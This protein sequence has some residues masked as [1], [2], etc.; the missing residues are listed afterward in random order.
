M[1]LRG[2]VPFCGPCN[3]CQGPGPTWS[4]LCGHRQVFASLDP[5][6]FVC[7]KRML[8]NGAGSRQVSRSTCLKL[9]LFDLGHNGTFRHRCSFK[10]LQPWL[11]MHTQM[12]VVI[13]T[14]TYVSTWNKGF[15][16][17]YLFLCGIHCYFLCSSS[18]KRKRVACPDQAIS[19]TLWD[20]KLQ[21]ERY[22]SWWSVSV[23]CC[24]CD[25]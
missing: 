23:S 8:V 11:G 20:H 5:G 17:S 1:Q 16:K 14:C 9:S 21:F 25:K 15:I 7:K 24:C 10:F 22:T 12:P 18:L 4:A 2:K 6:S 13:N 19:C 3:L